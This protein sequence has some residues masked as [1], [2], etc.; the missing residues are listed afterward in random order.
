M[1]PEDIEA[2]FAYLQSTPPVSNVVPAPIGP[3]E[4]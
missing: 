3:E 1:K 2:L 4:L